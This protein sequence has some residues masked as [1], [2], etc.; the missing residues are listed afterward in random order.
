MT[1]VVEKDPEHEIAKIL[2]LK[3]CHLGAQASGAGAEL[4]EGLL[5]TPSCAK[6]CSSNAPR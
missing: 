6:A 4:E 5:N 3:T 1:A 2:A